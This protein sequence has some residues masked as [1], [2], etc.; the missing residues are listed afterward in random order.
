MS[1]PLLALRFRA[2]PCELRGVRDRVADVARRLPW[3]EQSA[4][5]LV[6]AVNEACMNVIQH[7]Y[8]DDRSGEIV[9]EILDNA[10]S[11]EVILTDFAAPV[12]LDGIRPRD[13]DDLRPGGLGTHF[14]Q[15]IMDECT[16]AHLEGGRGNVLRM[17]KRIDRPND[18]RG[19][20]AGADGGN[21]GSTRWPMK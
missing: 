1:A 18:R 12:D 5:H 17:R 4:Q 7:A 11:I 13:L 21:P 2:D 16:Y 9:L 19:G 6:V 3:S 14:M 10:D 20:I 15:E 8:K